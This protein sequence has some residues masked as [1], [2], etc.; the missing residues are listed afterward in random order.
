M[1]LILNYKGLVALC[2]KLFLDFFFLTHI[3]IDTL[4]AL[5]CPSGSAGWHKLRPPIRSTSG[6]SGQGYFNR[7]SEHEREREREK[8]KETEKERREANLIVVASNLL[9]VASSLQPKSD[10]LQFKKERERERYIYIQIHRERERESGR[11]RECR[12][13]LRCWLEA[14]VHATSHFPWRCCCIQWRGLQLV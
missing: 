12:A 1:T 6:L 7:L 5:W 11:E 3:H 2:C 8:D 10:G 4:A 14:A 9:A 13:H